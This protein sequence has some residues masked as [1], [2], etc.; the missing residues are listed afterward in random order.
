MVILITIAPIAFC[1]LLATSPID[2][3]SFRRED[4]SVSRYSASLLEAKLSRALQ[5]S[6]QQK[7]IRITDGELTSYL[8]SRAG[9]SCIE[10]P[11]ARFED[12]R[13]R[14]NG[15]LIGTSLAEFPL[16]LVLTVDR[17]RDNPR[18]AVE[19]AR[20]GTLQ[21]PSVAL[22]LADQALEGLLGE[23]RSRVSWEKLQMADGVIEITIR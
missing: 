2:G 18:I 22:P 8:A 19:E 14:L 5:D 10:S 7:T 17:N 3:N 11:Q 1:V 15:T 12:G 13:I 4:V 20:L 6:E 21:V 9:G 16:H 23:W